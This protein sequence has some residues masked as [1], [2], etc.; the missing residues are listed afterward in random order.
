ML[1][2]PTLGNSANWWRIF[3][4]S[5]ACSL[6]AEVLLSK[7][8][9]E[10]LQ[11]A[12][13]RDRRLFNNQEEV[14][15]YRIFERMKDTLRTDISSWLTNAGDCKCESMSTVSDACPVPVC[16]PQVQLGEAPVNG[17]GNSDRHKVA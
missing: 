10:G 4:R 12:V 16:D 13:T 8:T 14:M 9:V 17:G 6:E 11:A 3:G 1:G 5:H 7:A 15:S 2:E